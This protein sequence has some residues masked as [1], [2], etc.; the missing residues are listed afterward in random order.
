MRKG[1]SYKDAG[2]LG[3]IKTNK[4]LQEQ[5]QS[6]KQTYDNNPSKCHHCK[7]ELSYKNRHNKYC[8]SSCAASNNNIGNRK[9]GRKRSN[10]LF[11]GEKTNSYKGKYCS[12]KCKNNHVWQKIKEKII[13]G[14]YKTLANRQ[15]RKFLFEEREYKCESCGLKEWKGEEIPLVCDHINGDS[16]D[17]SSKNLRLI[18]NNCDA[19]SPHFKSKNRGKGRFLRRLKRIEQKEKY[20]FSN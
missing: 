19:I 17:N 6:R 5:F 20:G 12:R 2:R 8:N 16:T 1:L 9:W 10:C 18:C 14:Q 15:L 4:K 11:C 13:S 7:K 3:W